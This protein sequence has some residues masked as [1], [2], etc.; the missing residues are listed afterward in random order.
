MLRVELFENI[1]RDRKFEG[2]PIRELARRH[3]VHR[4]TVRQ[5]LKNAVPPARKEPVRV[6]PVMG[7]FKGIVRGWL[8]ADYDPGGRVPK[9][10]R[11]TATRVWQRLVDEYDARVSYSTVRNFVRGVKA[12]LANR[13]RDVM[14]P[15]V[16]LLGKEA[17]VDFGLFEVLISGEQVRVSMF[18]MRLSASGKAFHVAFANEA[19]E[20][21]LEGHRLAFEY[22]GG[23][24]ER[25]RYDN[26]K[27]AVS[28]VLE[29]RNRHETERFIALRSHYGFEPFY[30]EPG[31]EGAHEKGGVEGEVGRFRRNHLVPLPQVNSMSELNLLIAECDR[32]DDSRHI[33]HRIETV[34]QAFT[35][36]VGQLRPLPAEPF[37]TATPTSC[38]VDTKARIHVRG[39]HYSVPARY[40]GHKIA[41]RVGADHIEARHGAKTIARHDRGVHRGSQHLNL[42]H[43]LE[44]L[45]TKPGA[46]ASSLPLELARQK[47]LFTAT[48][49]K[50]WRAARRKLGDP[51]GTRA[52]IE[53]L[54]AQRHLPAETIT[55]AIEETLQAGSI[56]P[57]IVISQAREHHRRSTQQTATPINERL[58]GYD[59]AMPSLASYDSLLK[60][61]AL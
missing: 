11:H 49:D 20:A 55:A 36:E 35:K 56:N 17:E 23:I 2:S 28:K 40:V 44:T 14:I 31:I 27:S 54:L 47:G 46:L 8:E 60:A 13:T 53:I 6:A 16:H 30:C 39:C 12:E 21:F 24:P 5:A 7:P 32:P 58:R 41:V 15:Q 18:V 43:Y 50:Y 33:D 22:L 4:R 26:L 57:E 19:Q 3:G 45:I 10:Q 1:R 25:I 37:D 38:R 42:D 34:G 52:L 51:K 48:H 29:G 61:A 59:R 9:K